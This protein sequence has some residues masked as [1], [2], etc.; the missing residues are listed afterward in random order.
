MRYPQPIA[1]RAGQ[2]SVWDYPRPPR[3]E[4]TSKHLH[5][6]VNEIVV[7]DTRHGFRTL[8]TSHPPVYYFPPSDVRR[9]LLEP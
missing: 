1:P 5:V 8:E 6:V 4:R 9:E 3:L 7:A 2:E